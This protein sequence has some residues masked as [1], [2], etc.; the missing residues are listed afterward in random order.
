MPAVK[1]V[2]LIALERTYN[3]KIRDIAFNVL[4]IVFNNGHKLL[5]VE[6]NE[7]IK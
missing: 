1:P 7:L 5:T 3:P 2:T 6:F 4:V